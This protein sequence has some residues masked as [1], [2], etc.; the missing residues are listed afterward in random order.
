MACVFHKTRFELALL[1]RELA[2]VDLAAAN[3]TAT[4]IATNTTATATA[5]ALDGRLDCMF[6]YSALGHMLSAALE[7]ATTIEALAVQEEAQAQA[8]AQTQTQ[9]EGEG[10]GVDEGLKVRLKKAALDVGTA[11]LA[12]ATL[13][14]VA[15]GHGS[16][17]V[18]AQ[19]VCQSRPDDFY[20]AKAAFARA[21]ARDPVWPEAWGGMGAACLA[22]NDQWTGA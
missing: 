11:L 6:N 13:T 22:D 21:I 12:R 1:A 14:L 10:E 18:S 7:S 2:P 8:Q 16:G 19:D 3:T 4:T 20:A 17:L 9:G 5:T 15:H